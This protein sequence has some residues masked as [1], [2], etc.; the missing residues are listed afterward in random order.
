MVGGTLVSTPTAATAGSVPSAGSCP[1][2][3][4]SVLKSTPARYSRTVALTF[5]DGPGPYTPAVLDALKRE[6][7]RATFFVTGAHVKAYPATARRI[8]AEGH[9]LANHTYSHPQRIAGSK[10]YGRFSDLSITTQASQ[11]DTTSNAI[12][13]ATRTRPCF[14]RAPGGW[15]FSSTTQSLARSRGMSVT[16]WTV[17]TEDWRQPGYLST[18]WQNRIYS[19]AT[20]P[21]YA[22]PI[23]LM[24]DAK[25]L[26]VDP[27]SSYRRNTA[28]VVTRVIRFYKARGYVFTDPAGRRL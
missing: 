14:F 17:D 2:P 25:G 13:A 4:T 11:M 9:I 15:H 26:S 1:A 7:V 8:V 16:H 3:A 21:T 19:R 20:S 28:V 6:G 24:H 23:I 18:Y 5:D 12:I 22:H 10:P 27:V